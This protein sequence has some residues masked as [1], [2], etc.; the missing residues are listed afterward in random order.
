MRARGSLTRLLFLVVGC[1]NLGL[2][3][4]ESGTV[5]KCVGENGGVIYQAKPCQPEAEVGTIA[6][7]P[8]PDS[9]PV[10]RRSAQTIDGWPSQNVERIEPPRP[11]AQ[12]PSAKP[13]GYKCVGVQRTWA[14]L[15]RCPDREYSTRTDIVS[16]STGPYG[17]PIY[18]PRI[19]SSSTPVTSVAV[20]KSEY[21][22]V[23]RQIGGSSASTY[24][25][26]KLRC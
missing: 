18:E 1:L 2:A 16:R 24:Q 3:F 7:K 13:F 6:F 11:V 20:N 14:S 22:A 17:S 4:A 10:S 19:S 8:E 25:Y 15:T 9:A 5:Y 23:L 12:T 21:C 26:N